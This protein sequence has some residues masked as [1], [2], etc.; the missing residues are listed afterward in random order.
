MKSHGVAVTEAR[1][2]DHAVYFISDPDGNR[3]EIRD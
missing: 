3:I 1:R 2:D